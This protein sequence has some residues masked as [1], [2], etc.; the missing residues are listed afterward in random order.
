M[1]A[2]SPYAPGYYLLTIIGNRLSLAAAPV[3][4]A[5]ERVGDGATARGTMMVAAAANTQHSDGDSGKKN[6][7]RR[8]RRN[9]RSEP[10]EE[11]VNDAETNQT[12][13]L[14]DQ[15]KRYV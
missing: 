12:V 13:M 9:R 3:A 14:E 4:V 5:S 7:K 6:C 10:H 1:T 11:R 8:N 15:Q 2:I